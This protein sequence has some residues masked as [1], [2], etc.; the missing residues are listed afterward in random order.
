MQKLTLDLKKNQNNFEGFYIRL[1][2]LEQNINH[3]FIFAKTHYEKDQHAFIQI[4]DGIK[5]T[6][7]YLRFPIESFKFKDG[8]VEIASNILSLEQLVINHPSIRVDVTLSQHDLLTQ[9]SAMGPLKHLPLECF[10]DVVYLDAVAE[11]RIFKNNEAIDFKGTSYMEKTYGRRFPQRWFWLQAN[12]FKD[13][14]SLKFTLAGGSVPTLKWTKFGF[15]LIIHYEGKAYRFAT[16]NMAKF[17][18]KETMEHVIFE[19]SKRNLK[20]VLKA[21][22]TKTTKLLGPADYGDMILDVFE[23][24]NAKVNLTLKKGDQTI[25]TADSETA[26]FEWMFKIK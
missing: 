14:Q 22:Q 5:K 2:N 11:G 19:V 3:A 15:F 24:V 25:V 17:K 21:K 6:N 1:L 10:Q 16:Y 12:D 23:S 13:A 7:Q 9:K 20:V 4:F 26:G 18:V 8:I